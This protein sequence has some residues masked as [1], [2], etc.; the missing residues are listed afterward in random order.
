[1]ALKCLCRLIGAKNHKPTSIFCLSSFSHPIWKALGLDLVP[2][3]PQPRSATELAQL[4]KAGSLVQT[5]DGD[6]DYLVFLDEID[7]HVFTYYT[8]LDPLESGSAIN[9]V[10]RKLVEG[11]QEC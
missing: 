11:H 8:Y 10:E 4:S 5:P 7:T 1:M 6:D 3:S 2:S 9:A